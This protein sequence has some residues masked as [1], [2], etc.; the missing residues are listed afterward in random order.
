L[1]PRIEQAS[2]LHLERRRQRR[3]STVNTCW[4]AGEGAAV[5]AR[6]L[7]TTT[8]EKPQ[9]LG[10]VSDKEENQTQI[11]FREKPQ[12][13]LISFHSFKVNKRSTQKVNM[14]SWARGY[15]HRDRGATPSPNTHTHTHT[16][17]HTQKYTSHE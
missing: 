4:H 14:H 10:G 17:T 2:E 1:A 11:S 8:E 7:E 5:W 9:S 16:H 15:K 12:Y 13:G 3:H 6:G